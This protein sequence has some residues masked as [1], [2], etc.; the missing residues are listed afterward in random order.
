MNAIFHQEGAIADLTINR[1]EFLNALDEKTLQDIDEALGKIDVGQV[2]AL[3]VTGAGEKSFV[4]GADI[5]A[6][7]KKT[8]K[9]ALYF[10]QFGQSV[11]TKLE[12]LPIITIACV[13]GYALGGGLE[14]A[15]ACDFILAEPKARFGQ[16]EVHLGII[17]GF[18]GCVRLAR[19]VG[20]SKAKEM[21]FSGKT[22]TAHEALKIGLCDVLT[23]EGEG[24]LKKA[25]QFLEPMLSQSIHAISQAKTAIQ[26]G[27]D[28]AIHEALLVE[29]L[30]FGNCFA[31]PDSKE[32]IAAFLE[33]RAPKFN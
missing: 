15:L 28:L 18:G 20:P 31:H 24:I 32:G 17:P 8:P 12:S 22:I 26:A 10:A 29:R 11:F 16:P 14:L 30:A 33:K 5:K 3:R 19:R 9:E 7:Q 23:Q 27:R 25:E 4:A 6:M 21:I 1:P 13:N 2:R